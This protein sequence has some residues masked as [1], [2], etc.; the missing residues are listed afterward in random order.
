[1]KDISWSASLI[2]I[3]L[4]II[5]SIGSYMRLDTQSDSTIQTMTETIRSASINNVNHK[6]RINQGEVYLLKD[7]FEDDF[8][9][10]LTQS[11]VFAFGEDVEFEYEYLEDEE[12]GSLKGIRVIAHGEQVYQATAIVDVSSISDRSNTE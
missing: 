1:M 9:R 7:S 10:I 11:S 5:V 8:E 12:T 4:V 3:G 6:S 2:I